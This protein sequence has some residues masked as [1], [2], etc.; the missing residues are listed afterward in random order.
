MFRIQ[1]PADKRYATIYLTTLDEQGNESLPYANWP[2]SLHFE[3]LENEAW[4]VK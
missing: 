4:I 3:K 2:V 1:L